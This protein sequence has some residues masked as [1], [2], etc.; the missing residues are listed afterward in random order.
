MILLILKDNEGRMY[1]VPIYIYLIF[2]LQLYPKRLYTPKFD[3]IFLAI[4]GCVY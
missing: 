4:C 2:S 1:K 3:Y